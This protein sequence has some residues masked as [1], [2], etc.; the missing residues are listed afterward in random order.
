MSVKIQDFT[1]NIKNQTK[2]KASI[3]LRIACDKVVETARPN[4]PKDKGNLRQ[5]VLKQ[6]LGLH[7]TLDWRKVYASYQERGMRRDG[8]RRVKNYTTPGT[9]AHFAENAV[10]EVVAKTNIIAKMANLL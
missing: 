4:T 2:Q 9:A 7:A 8:T 10:K 3:F 1:G 6:V 5:D